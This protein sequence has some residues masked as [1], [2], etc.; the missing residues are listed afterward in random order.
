MHDLNTHLFESAQ[1]DNTYA[2]LLDTDSC[3]FAMCFLV[4]YQR[5]K[6]V[7]DAGPQIAM[8]RHP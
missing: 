2:W 7:D 4:S 5:T 1:G 8:T 6:P 3:R